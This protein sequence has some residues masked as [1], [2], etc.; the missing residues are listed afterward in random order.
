[1]AYVDTIDAKWRWKY[2]VSIP[3]TLLL[4]ASVVP[5]SYGLVDFKSFA[6][7]YIDVPN[8]PELQLSQFSIEVT[9]RIL[10]DPSERGYIVSKSSSDNGSLLLDQNYA[11]FVTPTKKIGGGF[12]ADDGTTQYVYSPQITVGE[13]HLAKLIYDGSKLRMSLDGQTVS[14]KTVNKVPDNSTDGPLRIGAN[15]NDDADK[16]FVGDVD[17]VKLVDR[18]TAT[19]VYFNDFSET[20]EPPVSSENCSDIPVS[21]MRGAV[22]VDHIL[23]RFEDDGGPS[24]PTNYVQNSM[25]FIKANGMNLVRVPYYWE[26][27]VSWPGAFMDELDLIAQSAQANDVCV[28]FDNHHWYTSSY[29]ANVDFGKSGKPKGFP[30]F[31]MQGYPT[32]GD[33]ESTAGLFWTDFWNNDIEVGGETIWE[34]HADFVGDVIAQVDHYD[35][36]AGYEI[37]NEPHL[38]NTSQYE[39]L[40]AYHTFMAQEIRSLTDKKIV[41]DRE[42]ARG[43]Q[44]MPSM[45][46]TIVPQ[47]VSGLVYGPH[48]YSVPTQGSQG[49][50]QVEN[51]KEWAQEWGVEVLLGEWS[52]ETQEEVDAFV[53]VFRDAG[54]GW[55]YYKWAPS[56]TVAGDHLGNIIYENKSSGK[57]IYLE[58]LVDAMNR[59]L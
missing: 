17:S 26:A 5:S 59:L 47:G 1:M 43:F 58:Q 35:S 30:S 36:V 13:W 53:S 6:G 42:T 31:V 34:L 4:L 40:G 45:E 49:E 33:Y 3:L 54:F 8:A 37:L 9:F 52:G 15:A 38:F 7:D 14:S 39:R 57:T 41:F 48:L 21:E 12:R 16:F 27:Y 25:K 19:R 18:S 20:A 50:N 28:I 51:F 56:K 24:A 10:Q 44:R 55:T 22:F 46:Q 32:T 29:F 11:L 23:S 2:F